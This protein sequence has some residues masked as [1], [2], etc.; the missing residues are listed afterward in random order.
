MVTTTTKIIAPHT[1]STVLHGLHERGTITS[2]FQSMETGLK[3]SKEWADQGDV[4]KSTVELRS[5]SGWSHP[6]AL[7]LITT[8]I[9]NIKHL[10]STE[11]PFS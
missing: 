7:C 4:Y 11:S 2:I 8:H 9:L 3:G 6:K 5:N 10:Q 1:E